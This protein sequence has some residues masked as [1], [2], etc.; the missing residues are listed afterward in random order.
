MAIEI[1][2]GYK[3]NCDT[4]IS[5]IL[6]FVSKAKEKIEQ[7][8]LHQIAASILSKQV[9]YKDINAS[10]E[11]ILKQ[12]KINDCTD[13][14]IVRAML[15]CKPD[16]LWTPLKMLY[17]IQ[18][19]QATQNLTADFSEYL[20]RLTLHIYNGTLYGILHTSNPE[21]VT[22]FEQLEEV[23]DFS[24]DGSFLPTD[25]IT[26]EEWSER[27]NVWSNI[28]NA[29]TLNK[30][31]FPLFQTETLESCS[32]SE[33]KG[34]I[35]EEDLPSLKYRAKLQVDISKFFKS[36]TETLD[37]MIA[38]LHSREFNKQIDQEAEVIMKTLKPINIT[39]FI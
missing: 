5:E 34:L 4:D 20:C 6:S 23:S 30:I 37:E 13:E 32:V 18:L 11:E 35:T 28:L 1:K 36:K 8:G 29:H 31:S 33:L 2:H 22:V 24:Y 19:K 17:R 25:G 14:T 39:D 15:N 16:D 10:E 38:F 26:E 27:G 3:V 21:Y 7:T 9:Y 12:Y